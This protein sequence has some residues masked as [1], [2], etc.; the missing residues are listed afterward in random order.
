MADGWL[1]ETEAAGGDGPSAAGRCLGSISL[2]GRCRL[3]ELAILHG[4]RM[5]QAGLSTGMV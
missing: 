2:A 5:I 4:S 1:P 3:L